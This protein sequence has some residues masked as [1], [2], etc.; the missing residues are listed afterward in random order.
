MARNALLNGSIDDARRMLQEVQLR[1]VFR[2][3]TPDNN[4]PATAGP[5]ASDVA[6]A[7]AALGDNDTR[8]GLQFI[9]RA[10]VDISRAPLPQREPG[11]AL[12]ATGYAPPYPQY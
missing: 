2:P 9:A 4:E 6:H 3:V 10:M 5:S 1:L 7:L 8:R 12:S 11:P